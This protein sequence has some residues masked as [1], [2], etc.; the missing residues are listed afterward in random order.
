MQ[1]L[2]SSVLNIFLFLQNCED[3]W[4]VV[5]SNWLVYTPE[6]KAVGYGKKHRLGGGEHFCVCTGQMFFAG[7]HSL[8]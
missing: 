6:A 4:V 3:I 5:S 1:Q 2:V 8:V 7:Y